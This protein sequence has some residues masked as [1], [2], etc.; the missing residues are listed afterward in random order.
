LGKKSLPT[1]HPVE[2]YYAKYIKN[3]RSSKNPQITQLKMGYRAK[4]NPLL[5]NLELLRS[6]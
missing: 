5:R 3:S 4:Q 2:G 1:P 6:T